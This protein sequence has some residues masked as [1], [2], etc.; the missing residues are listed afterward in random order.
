MN[1]TDVCILDVWQLLLQV[2]GIPTHI[3]SGQITG[4]KVTFQAI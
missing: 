3:D 4:N 1:M 2:L